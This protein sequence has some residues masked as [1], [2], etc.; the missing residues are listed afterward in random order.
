M[1]TQRKPTLREL[2]E[3]AF[4]QQLVPAGAL[5]KGSGDILYI[6]GRTSL[7]LEPADGRGRRLQ[8]FQD[9]ERGFAQ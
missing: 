6:H 2:T 8:H 1:P 4:L 3:Q 5:V 7:F 9:G